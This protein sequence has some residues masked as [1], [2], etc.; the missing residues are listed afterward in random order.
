M[1]RNPNRTTSNPLKIEPQREKTMRF[2]VLRRTPN[3]R[4][5]HCCNKAT[6]N[7]KH[8]RYFERSPRHDKSRRDHGSRF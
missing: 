1:Q 3:G 8:G 2:T 7:G 4:I 6:S 5:F